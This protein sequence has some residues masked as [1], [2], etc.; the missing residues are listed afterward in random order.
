M[1]EIWDIYD[2]ERQLTGRSC[3]RGE[4][5][6]PGDYHLAVIAWIRD[7]ADRYLCAKRDAAKEFYPGFWESAG[8]AVLAGEDSLTAVLREVREELGVALEPENGE[9]F[10]S[11]RNGDTFFDIWLFRQDIDIREITLQ[12]GENCEVRRFYPAEIREMIKTRAFMPANY[13]EDLFA[14]E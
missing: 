5:F 9:I 12:T 4:T 3:R 13:A 10:R 7:S 2:E 11:F 8:G 1:T 6:L 14:Y